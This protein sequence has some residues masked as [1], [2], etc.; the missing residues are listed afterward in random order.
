[1]NFPIFR[2]RLFPLAQHGG[3][4]PGQGGS[5]VELGFDLPV[6]LPH[7]P[8]AAQGFGFVKTPRNF[9]FH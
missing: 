9:V 4:V 2:Q 5:F 1:V 7:R 8:S 6:E 3:L